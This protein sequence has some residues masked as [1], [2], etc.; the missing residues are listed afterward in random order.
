MGKND[1]RFGSRQ[2]IRFGVLFFSV[3]INQRK[4]R[5]EEGIKSSLFN[6]K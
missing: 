5:E 1:R 6:A 3:N 4:E 2:E